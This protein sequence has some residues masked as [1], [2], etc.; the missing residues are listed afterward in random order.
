MAGAA[1]A[2][3]ELGD[4]RRHHLDCPAALGT[5]SRTSCPRP[6]PGGGDGPAHKAVSCPSLAGLAADAAFTPAAVTRY[7][8]AA[9]I[10]AAAITCLWCGPFSIRLRRAGTT[11]AADCPPAVGAPDGHGMILTGWC[12]DLEDTTYRVIWV[13]PGP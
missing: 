3:K 13:G 7:G 5:P 6:V 2:G 8:K 1:C 11:P 9:A 12:V 10:G 4:F